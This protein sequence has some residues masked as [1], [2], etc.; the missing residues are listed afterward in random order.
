MNNKRWSSDVRKPGGRAH[1]PRPGP[2]LCCSRQ[3][4]S[5]ACLI[6]GLCLVLSPALRAETSLL[7]QEQRQQRI[8]N[9]T[10][11]SAAVLAELVDE[12]GRNGLEGT[13][14]EILG[15]IQKVLGNVSGELMPEIVGQLQEARTGQD[16]PG[17]RAQALNAFAG[18]KSAS[19]QMRQVLLE[20]QRQ[21]ALYQLAERVQVLGD[22]QSS[23]LHETVALITA[24][25]KPS[26]SR[27]QNDFAISRQLQ[28]TEQEALEKEVGLVL[29]TLE[30]MQKTFEG[31]LEN[32]PGEA[33]AFAAGQKLKTALQSALLDLKGNRLMSAAGHEKSARDTLWRLVNIL[34]PDRDALD[35]LLDGLEKLDELIAGEKEVIAQTEDLDNKE[36]EKAEEL[37]MND[38]RVVNI[39]KQIASMERRLENARPEEQVR[40]ATSME[41]TKLRLEKEIEKARQRLGVDTPEMSDLRRAERVQRQQAELVDRTD[42]LGQELSGLVP[43]VSSL[44]AAA[45][46]PMQEARAALG[47]AGLPEKLKEAALPPEK[48]AL[49]ALEEAR[50]SLVEEIEKA[51][52]VEEVPLDKLEHLK[53]LL[54]K[55]QNLRKEE[56]V[57]KAGS[58]EAER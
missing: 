25:R 49:T 19:Y 24:S 1:G 4:M 47:Q 23:N 18:Q 26:A 15:G 46:G 48:S 17:R 11:D 54:E 8:G 55:V 39:E 7:K 44:L 29:S 58:A 42:F 33:L 40:I 50:Q 5:R 14:V 56:E 16:E 43:E 32:R 51:Q 34:Q 37:V 12:F 22:R 21:L 31:S 45:V 53:E 3:V 38:E 2:V 13:D 36:R 27:R 57:L 41:K 20:Y 9:A 6:L 35:E 52:F 30:G 10:S 28:E